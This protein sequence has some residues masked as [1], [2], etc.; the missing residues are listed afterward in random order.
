[1][2]ITD[3][4]VVRKDEDWELFRQ[5]FWGQRERQHQFYSTAAQSVPD[6]DE[7]TELLE[8]VTTHRTVEYTSLDFQGL[9]ILPNDNP[10]RTK[11]LVR[12]DYRVMYSHINERSS[13]PP[14]S[15]GMV[16]TGQPGIGKLSLSEATVY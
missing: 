7:A 5:K 1:M 11:L 15:G 3:F 10:P 12:D 14:Y 16:V 13:S 6:V 9:P 2:K 8:Q 4:P